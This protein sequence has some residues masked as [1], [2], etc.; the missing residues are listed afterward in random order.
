MDTAT[1]IIK[2]GKY[3]D[4][5]KP[6]EDVDFIAIK[7]DRIIALGSGNAFEKYLGDDTTIIGYGSDKLIMPGFHDNHIH[8]VLAGMVDEVLDLSGAVSA[9]NA[10]ELVAEFAKDVPK[11]EWVIGIGWVHT[12]WPNEE[13]PTKEIL[14]EVLP[15]HPAFLM[16]SELHAVWVN[17]PALEIAGIDNSTPD[18]PFGE[19]NRDENGEA[20]GYL[21]E[22]ALAI[23]GKIALA[24]S[25]QTAERLISS[26]MKTAAS[27]GITSVSDLTPYLGIDLSLSSVFHSMDQA[28]KLTLRINAGEDLL[29]P[30]DTYFEK[31]AKYDG[32]MFRISYLKQFLDG[33]VANYTAMLLEDYND[34]PGTKGGSLLDVSQLTGLVEAAQAKGVSVRF[35]SCGDGSARLALDQFENAINKYPDK[36]TRHQ[37]EH[38]EVVNPEDI[39]RFKELGV[40][41][42]IQPEHVICGIDSYEQNCYPSRL[43]EV[44][45]LQTWPFKSLLNA[46]AVLA[47]GSDAPV[48][49]RNPMDGIATST[50]RI[51]P[52]GTPPGGWNAKEILTVAELLTAYTSGASYAE[53]REDELGKLAVGY[54]ADL[55]VLNKDLLSIPLTDIVD[56]RVL[57]TIVNGKI[58]Y[59][60]QTMSSWA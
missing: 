1:L 28:G 38:L 31:K 26:Y 6:R 10:A 3:F 15:N 45:N 22:T 4:G 52:D 9:R 18:P 13:L 35:H 51:H 33:V 16:D 57:L 37:I 24:F 58:V 5:L 53:R 34:N 40:I 48:A 41:A 27:L 50:Q 21:Y 23:V 39:P 46:G 11:G 32:P 55:A 59:E 43:G 56:T 8:L 19:I 17:S 25:D 12:S 30:L 14:D 7:D 29:H 2:G 42:S 36:G 49:S 54:L 60:K 44:R 47:A 20:T